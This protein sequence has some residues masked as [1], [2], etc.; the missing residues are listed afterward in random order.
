MLHTP[1]VVLWKNSDGA[2]V[3][4]QRYATRYAEPKVVTAVA[5][6]V[7]PK[8][9]LVRNQH[10][11]IGLIYMS[12]WLKLSPLASLIRSVS[13]H[14]PRRHSPSKFLATLL[15]S[16][17]FSHSP[18]F[19]LQETTPGPTYQFTSTP[20]TWISTWQRNLKHPEFHRIHHHRWIE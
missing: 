8:H 16:L 11:V 15:F 14:H 12:M 18:P 6:L 1:L 9:L 2:T 20:A 10:A 3:I 5:K 19:L 13:L 4:S 7:E 17:S